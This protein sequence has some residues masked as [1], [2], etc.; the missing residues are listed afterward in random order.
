MPNSAQQGP[1]S[2]DPYTLK[3][4]LQQ[5][6]RTTKLTA[7]LFTRVNQWEPPTRPSAE[8]G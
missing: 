5:I 2:M 3:E 4:P 6:S 7:A 1:K 8:N